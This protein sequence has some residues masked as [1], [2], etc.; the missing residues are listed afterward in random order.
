ML[1]GT[2]VGSPARTGGADLDGRSIM[3]TGLIVGGVAIAAAVIIV[4]ALLAAWLRIYN[5]LV[6]KKN[7]VDN[8]F[9]GIDA[10]LK[11]RF[12]LIP[13]LVAVVKQY[14]KHEAETLIKV[15]QARAQAGSGPASSNVRI[16]LE[17]QLTKVLGG[18]MVAVERYP[19]LKADRAFLDLQGSLNEVEEQLSAARR[20]YNT[21]VTELNN[22]IQMF[23]SSIIAASM[24]LAPREPFTIPEAQRENPDVRSLFAQ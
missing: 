16:D 4:S 14:A 24:R 20:F 17:N 19:E 9:A 1:H 7:A 22:A 6:E 10:M 8:A 18:V 23:P 13:S 12:D 11:K 5:G 15:T 2:A 3:S 21:A